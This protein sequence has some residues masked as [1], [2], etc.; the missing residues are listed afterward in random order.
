MQITERR[1]STTRIKVNT[2]LSFPLCIL[3]Q[4]IASTDKG[5]ERSACILERKIVKLV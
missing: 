4:R 5:T 2:N 3:E 1:G